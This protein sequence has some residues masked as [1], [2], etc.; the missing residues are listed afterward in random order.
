MQYEI[1]NRFT[2]EVQFT[3]EIDCDENES[4]SLK[5]G[6]S[7]KW[8]IKNNANLRN[9]NL[10]N[11]DLSKADL[12]NADLSNANLRDAN[13]RNA[14]LRNANLSNADFRYANLRYA[15]F[16]YANLR[17]ANLSNADLRYADLRDANLRN[18]DLLYADLRMLQ[19]DIYTCWIQKEHIR[20]GCQ[21]HKYEDWINFDDKEISKMDSGA[22]D[23]W[24]IWKPIIMQ[25][26]KTM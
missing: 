9:A 24:K 12:S 14:D 2:D 5:V 17:N 23:W 22:L 3:A 8:A 15:D 26:N 19:T 4:I 13:L 18:A 1:K 10:S 16:R 20:I 11:A 6:L 21:Y 7:V 25:I